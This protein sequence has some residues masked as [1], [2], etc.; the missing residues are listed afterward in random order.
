MRSWPYAGSVD[1]P[2][3]PLNTCAAVL[4]LARRVNAKRRNAIATEKAAMR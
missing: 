3:P 2:V 1:V 4:A